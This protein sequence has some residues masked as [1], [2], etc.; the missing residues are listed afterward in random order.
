MKKS[1]FLNLNARDFL[2]G[3]LVAV[4]TA[5]LTGVYQLLQMGG[6]LSWLTLKPV[7]MA[8]AAAGLSYLIKNLLSNS[9]DEFAKTERGESPGVAAKFLIIGI[10]LSA[11][12]VQ[13]QAQYLTPRGEEPA[14]KVSPWNG[15]FK[16]VDNS[17]FNIKAPSAG[18]SVWLF[19]P[20]VEISA[21]QLIP[22]EVEG[23]IFDVSSFQSVGMGVSYQ[24]FVEYNS[25]PYNNYGV[26]L[27]VL[28][29]AIPRETTSLNLS[30]VVSISALE[31]MNFGVGYNFGMKKPFLLTGLIYNFN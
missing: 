13:S 26:N 28:F 9:Q 19:R 16:P 10:V 12:S 17:I 5:L 14:K 20:T 6:D 18:R 31:F 1:K 2:K 4:L 23:K 22:S 24:H 29:D 7:V 25:E 11:F 27:L 21:M 15:F 30:T 3:L 8:S